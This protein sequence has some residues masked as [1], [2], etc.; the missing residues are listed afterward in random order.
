MGT[1]ADSPTAGLGTP[2]NVTGSNNHR[3]KLLN[4]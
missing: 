4:F 3:R 2:G 1:N